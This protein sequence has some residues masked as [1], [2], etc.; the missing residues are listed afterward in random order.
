MLHMQNVSVTFPPNVRALDNVNLQFRQGQFTVL[1]GQSGAGKSTLLRCLNL[2]Q[3]PT[4]GLVVGDD[5]QCLSG[6][7]KTSPR[8]REHRRHTAMVFQ[9]HQ[10]ILRQSAVKNVMVGMLA[11]QRA[12]Q[13]LLPN[14]K[15]NL[16]WAMQC[17]ERVDLLE[18]ARTRC[19]QL[20]GG[21][22]QRV[23]IAR[24]LAQRPRY[25]LADE[26]VASLDPGTANKVLSLIQKVCH[27]D[28]I[29][30]IVSLHQ[31]EL[32]RA[33]AQRV[34]A[35]ADGQV[36]FDGPPNELSDDHLSRI[37]KT[38]QTVN[39]SDDHPSIANPSTTT[40]KEIE[41]EIQLAQSFQ[42]YVGSTVLRP[43]H[44]EQRPCRQQNQS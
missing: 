21:Q 2:L 41:D 23:G 24:A 26:P 1:L 29:T 44:D 40:P 6:L 11:T 16:Q 36:I 18:K 31:V 39:A 28:H 42:R 43:D 25:L 15:A 20:S 38:Q 35:L 34:I 27:Q 8:L 3:S 13:S 19:D 14:S 37:Y 22:R 9:M 7:S 32:A 5:D 10:L 30:A 4:Q 17:L 33:Y 12:Y